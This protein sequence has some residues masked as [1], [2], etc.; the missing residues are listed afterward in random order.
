MPPGKRE[1]LGHQLPV[2]PQQGRYLQGHCDL[3]ERA[4]FYVIFHCT[5]SG[6]LTASTGSQN[7]FKWLLT[8]MS[9]IQHCSSDYGPASKERAPFLELLGPENEQRLRKDT[10]RRI[11]SYWP[12]SP[13]GNNFTFEGRRM[14]GREGPALSALPHLFLAMLL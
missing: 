3:L 11:H 4:V 12:S 1:R 7:L 9:V 2:A 14:G 13:A 8:R 6:G 5:Q 10:Q